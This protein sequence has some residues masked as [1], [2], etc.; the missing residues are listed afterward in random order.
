M[1]STSTRVLKTASLAIISATAIGLVAPSTIAQEN[2]E[3]APS[4]DSANSSK[5]LDTVIV[6]SRKREESLQDVPLSI[7]AI[8]GASLEEAAYTELNAV[9]RLS[10]NVFFEAADR[11][12]P[13]IFIRGI[14]TRGYDAGSDSSVG[15]FVDGVYLGRFGALDLD[16][17]DLERIE[18][19]KG[20]QGTLY[21]RNTIGGAL[22]VTTKDPSDTFVG[23]VSAEL[24]MGE[25]SDDMMYAVNGSLSGP[26]AENV[27]G[28]ISASRR[29]RDGY[30][31]I[32]GT[33]VRGGSEDSWAV[34]A[35]TLF[36]FGG[37]T[38]LR[39]AADYSDNDG[40]PLIL[41]PNQL[42][43]TGPGPV[44]PGFTIPNEPTD[45][46]RVPM[47][48][49]N[50]GIQKE[51]YGVSAQLDWSFNGL[52]FTSITAARGMEFTEL[53]DLEGTTLPFQV[54]TVKEDSDQFSQ[55]FRVLYSN[56]SID[57]LTGAFY[58]K[59]DVS[60]T[61]GIE[62]GPASLLSFLVAPAP[63]VW[64]F[65]FE[66]DATSVALFSQLDWR[67]TDQL[68]VTI[69]GRYSEDEKDVV[70]D[71]TT[72]V[73]GFIV[74]PFTEE[75]SVKWDSFDPSASVQ[76]DFSENV[77]AYV[78]WSTGYKSGAFQFIATSPLVAQ[79]IA[80]P[81]EVEATEVGLKSTLFD[82]KVRFNAAAFTMDYKD[83]Q[84]LRLSPIGGGVS[85]VVI[86]NAATSEIQGLEI[87]T[88]WQI[89]DNWSAD[90]N[91]GYLDATFDQ[92]VFNST[93]DFSG[94]TMPRSP[95]HTYNIAL[96]YDGES[97]WGDV[98][99]R[100][101]YSWRDELFF[102]ADNNLIDV[103][104]SEDALGLLDFSAQLSTQDNWTFAVW[105]KNLTDER[106]RRQVLNSTGNSQREIWAA[107][108][109]IGLRVGYEF[110]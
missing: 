87:E 77:M 44:A 29:F 98:S 84:Q 67:L 91:Y 45:P 105:G 109:S 3:P 19:L 18:V 55:E 39:L 57:W 42:G 34:R 43:A 48:V 28:S 110:N 56:D 99:A 108:R 66:L 52:D 50:Q 31:E 36:D 20:P 1:K 58:S 62:F 95:E 12:K 70:F 60:R 101:A 54:Y 25:S 64:D 16:L 107:P 17:M 69:G 90:F 94:N 22:A 72:T 13:L 75:L 97:S 37:G 79:Q 74:T 71:T 27:F 68:S 10:S 9:S 85:L 33:D 92:Y 6:T 49:Q 21:G 83:L 40:P 73:P 100:L 23:K 5:R 11:T 4:S 65:P 104:S 59:E 24:G 8:D 89:D 7:S 2:G 14:G 26:I 96:N 32:V 53:D 106:Y 35:K 78:S 46:Y 81:E 38:E 80:D 103:E 93:L 76:Y 102:E 88:V 47:D 82:G 41:V 30:Q 51:T 15:V 86:D 61:E 63:L